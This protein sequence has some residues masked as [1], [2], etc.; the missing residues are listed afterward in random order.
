VEYWE[1]NS[2]IQEEIID[3][4]ILH[5]KRD[6]QFISDTDLVFSLASTQLVTP[7]SM[8]ESPRPT[9]GYHKEP[10]LRDPIV[11]SACKPSGGSST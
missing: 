5:T 10:V 6:A 2:W 4:R 1:T 3:N 8:F 7:A 9:F 11:I